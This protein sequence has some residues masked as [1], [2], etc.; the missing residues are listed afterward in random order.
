M[1]ALPEQ[2]KGYY[3]ATR[4]N[5]QKIQAG[6]FSAGPFSPSYTCRSCSSRY[7]AHGMVIFFP[8]S[9]RMVQD[10]RFFSDHSLFQALSNLLAK[11]YYRLSDCVHPG[12]EKRK[13]GK[14]FTQIFVNYL[15]SDGTFF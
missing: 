2:R 15:G 1:P 10:I 14:Y 12:I 8:A 6:R 9:W 11:F 7:F 13:L 5:R 4:K 3:L